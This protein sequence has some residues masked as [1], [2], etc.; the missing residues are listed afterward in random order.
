MRKSSSGDAINGVVSK[1]TTSTLKKTFGKPGECSQASKEQSPSQ[2]SKLEHKQSTARS[3]K[4]TVCMLPIA[5]N[6]TITSIP[7]SPRP[8]ARSD[9]FVRETKDLSQVER[10]GTTFDIISQSTAAS[11]IEANEHTRLLSPSERRSLYTTHSLDLDSTLVNLQL[12]ETNTLNAK[13]S[14][15]RSRTLESGPTSALGF[16][17]TIDLNVSQPNFDMDSTFT[18]PSGVRQESINFNEGKLVNSSQAPMPDRATMQLPLNSTLSTERLLDLTLCKQSPAQ[19]NISQ[20]NAKNNTELLYMTSP[21]RRMISAYQDAFM[22]CKA[23]S[24]LPLKGAQSELLLPTHTPDDKGSS[25]EPMEADTTLTG[26]RLRSQQLFGVIHQNQQYGPS[27]AVSMHELNNDGGK[28]DL[29]E[30]TLDCSIEL[31]DI[32]LSSTAISQPAP[33]PFIGY[34]SAQSPSTHQQLLK[35]Q[36]S[37]ELDESLGILT[38]DQMKEFLDSTTNTNNLDLPLLLNMTNQQNSQKNNKKISFHQMRMDQTPSPEELPLDPVEVK[39][40]I[41]DLIAAQQQQQQTAFCNAMMA[42]QPQQ[43]RSLS[44]EPVSVSCETELSKADPMSKSNVSKISNSFITS[45]TSV[46]SL[47]TGY[48]GDGEMSRPASRGASDHSPSSG[49]TQRKVGQ[50]QQYLPMRRQDPMTDSDFFT[51][52]DA[53]DLFHRGDRRAQ[54]I[55]GQLYGP[56][57]QPTASVFISE[58]PQMEDSCMESSGIFTDV[59]NRC[60][61][62]LISQR[63]QI[64]QDIDMSPDA[65]STDTVKSNRVAQQNISNGANENGSKT[66]TVKL[67]TSHGQGQSTKQ[68]QL[69]LSDS[70]TSSTI[71]NSSSNDRISITT[72][73]AGIPLSNRTSYCSMDGGSGMNVDCKSFSS[74]E[75][76]FAPNIDRDTKSLKAGVLLTSTAASTFATSISSVKRVTSPRKHASL[77]SLCAINSVHVNLSITAPVIIK[78][79]ASSPSSK[80]S[81]ISNAESVNSVPCVKVSLPAR[82]VPRIKKSSSQNNTTSVSTA[83]PTV[84]SAPCNSRRTQSVNKWDAVMNK[85]ASNKLVKKNYN[86]VKPKVATGVVNGSGGNGSTTPSPEARCSLPSASAVQS[87]KRPAF[88]NAIKLINLKATS[89]NSSSDTYPGQQAQ[90]GKRMLQGAVKR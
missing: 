47:D 34:N 55:D 21:E 23:L 18:P 37:F 60:D 56:M 26:F 29:T 66:D 63:R 88:P 30:S 77:T 46:T 3:H 12:C 53:D 80:D 22:S 25:E 42:Q 62:D 17:E 79:A 35:K 39:T 14:L 2:K 72:E 69:Q 65:D 43:H 6:K 67:T 83:S 54:V 84:K 16:G 89:L 50:H 11:K 76:D 81:L 82:S 75:E 74:L 27:S 61:E 10:L 15:Q 45:V 19:L 58:D 40:D 48:Q 38:P 36:N 90:Q 8:F 1:K 64:T 87:S 4:E 31:C 7:H 28:Q 59:E 33:S 5:A 51:E 32:S 52:S 41:T 24:S 78:H 71:L 49:P 70:Q 20:D 73:T 44:T 86:E 13:E 85:I 57:H 9:T 68:Q